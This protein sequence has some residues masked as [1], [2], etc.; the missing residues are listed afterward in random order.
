MKKLLILILGAALLA[1]GWAVPAGAYEIFCPTDTDGDGFSDDPDVVCMH[2]AGADGFTMMADGYPQYMFSFT[3]VTG[4]PADQISQTAILA[5]NLPA[6][7]IRI[8]EGQELYLSLSNVG[9][10]MR[11][12]LFDPH[13]VHWHGFPNASTL[14]DGVPDSSI[15]VNMGATIHYYYNVVEPGTFMYHCHVEATEHIEMGMVGNLYVTPVQND[16]GGVPGHQAGDMYAYNDGD[17]STRYDVEKDIQLMDFDRNFH[18]QSVNTQP[19][20]FADLSY[21]YFLMNGRGYPDTVNPADI[22]N[23]EGYAAQNVDS[24]IIANQGD[25]VLLRLN[26]F[27]VNRFYTVELVGSQMRVIGRDSKIFRARG[28]AAGKDLSYMTN[29]V[30]IGGGQTADV[31]IDTAGMAPGTYFLMSR[32]LF[33]LNNHDERNG[34]MMTTLVVQ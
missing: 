28:D 18:D 19:L 21:H 11:P 23:S 13:T 25:K 12:D 17:G 32:N 7:L 1:T 6:P 16:A 30:D 9:M 14:H 31:L 4:V 33:A 22:I 27:S 8:K 20:G 5:A 29:S 15:S 24:R 2:L 26:N 34:G 10:M 3:D